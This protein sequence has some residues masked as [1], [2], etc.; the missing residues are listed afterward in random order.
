MF[1]RDYQVTSFPNGGAL[2]DWYSAGAQS[3]IQH[4][5]STGFD[6]RVTPLTNPVT[7]YGGMTSLS[8][9][10]PAPYPWMEMPADLPAFPA[11]TRIEIMVWARGTRGTANATAAQ[12]AHAAPPGETLTQN[13]ILFQAAAIRAQLIASATAPPPIP[14]PLSSLSLTDRDIRLKPKEDFRIRRFQIDS[15]C[16]GV[17][18]DVELLTSDEW[19][20]NT[21]LTGGP[22][23]TPNGQHDALDAYAAA[24]GMTVIINEI[25]TDNKG[26][27][28]VNGSKPDWVELHNISSAAVNIT[29]WTLKDSAASFLIPANPLVNNNIPPGGF[30]VILCGG[31]ATANEPYHR[32]G[33]GLSSSYGYTGGVSGGE[34]VTLDG[35][36]PNPV[37]RDTTPAQSSYGLQYTDVT[38]GRYLDP[39]H[40]ANQSPVKWGYLAKPTPGTA[41]SAGYDGP[42]GEPAIT[43]KNVDTQAEVVPGIYSRTA[44]RALTLAL[45]G[46]AGSTIHY[47]TNGA[48]PTAWSAIYDPASPPQFDRTVIVRAVALREG[49]RPSKVIT[50]SFIFKES[51]VGPAV[52]DTPLLSG[53]A[54]ITAQVRPDDYPEYSAPE[55]SSFPNGFPIPYSVSTTVASANRTAIM[56][57]LSALPSISLVAPPRDLF[58]RESAGIYASSTLTAYASDPHGKGWERTPSMEW[59]HPGNAQ[60]LGFPAPNINCTLSMSGNTNLQWVRTEKHSMTVSFSRAVSGVSKYDPNFAVFPQDTLTDA[61]IQKFDTLILRNPTFDSW[62]MS[63]TQ[64]LTANPAT[65]TYAKELF[66]R[67]SMDALGHPQLF[68]RWVHLYI[69]DLYWGAYLLSEKADDGTLDRRARTGGDYYVW[70]DSGTGVVGPD[71]TSVPGQPI[72]STVWNNLITASD[73]VAAVTSGEPTAQWDAI[74]ATFDLNSFIDY[75]LLHAYLGNSDAMTNNGRV[76]R[77][78]PSGLFTW[79]IYDVEVGADNAALTQDCFAGWWGSSNPTE[80]R[81]L[82]NLTN[83]SRFT[84]AFGD[85]A[86]RLCLMPTNLQNR[87]EDG[88]FTG[89]SVTGKAQV[90]FTAAAAAF[91]PI[92]LC[93]ALR[94][95]AGHS[96][97]PPASPYTSNAAAV[98]FATTSAG[99]PPVNGGFLAA[100]RAAFKSQLE[101]LRQLN[102]GVNPALPPPH[103]H[104]PHARPHPRCRCQYLDTPDAQHR[105]IHHLLQCDSQHHPRTRR[106]RSHAKRHRTARWCQL[107][108]HRSIYATRPPSG[109]DRH[110]GGQ[111]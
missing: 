7:Y 30:L 9:S 76:Y 82:R 107:H 72:P 4:Y 53:S 97:T 28:E 41:N 15:N 85:R 49:C 27:L 29:G 3:W 24:G 13:L 2:V 90:R 18:D 58:D 10:Y 101:T 80:A 33:F 16:N 84:Q 103:G 57:A 75:T 71:A 38:F 23:G 14:P 39:L 32:T 77:Q 19:Q 25:C 40:A 69:N 56:T 20:N 95:G 108:V 54:P 34:P 22:N 86:W 59:I 64:G 51:I 12:M 68:S 46:T 89:D 42:C 1:Y 70:K 11:P 63:A 17:S 73:A 67:D 87:A 8:R 26:S 47:T 88:F 48:V 55:L 92:R 6:L 83:S 105:W 93:E 35:P 31:N 37:Q 60:P 96:Y 91:E 21:D 36:A 66:A 65:N 110:P 45:T 52:G 74:R 43:M 5:F 99:S 94:W 109:H 106:S 100:R 50:R 61:A 44:H 78:M 102:P 111:H 81:M 98:A 62:T 104:R 79:F